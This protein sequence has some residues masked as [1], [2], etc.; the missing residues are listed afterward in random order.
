[1]SEIISTAIRSVLLAEPNIPT[2][3]TPLPAVRSPEIVSAADFRNLEP[4]RFVATQARVQDHQDNSLLAGESYVI[5]SPTSLDYYQKLQAGLD[6]YFP[7]GMTLQ[8][9]SNIQFRLASLTPDDI[10]A[11]L[12]KAEDN[13]YHYI[14]LSG[15][16]FESFSP[17]YSDNGGYLVIECNITV[18]T[19]GGQD[20]RG[21]QIQYHKATQRFAWANYL[22]NFNNN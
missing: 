10:S 5:G 19:E 20:E 22:D 13:V 15:V 2:S 17:R 9:L 7:E 16:S 21:L 12:D 14:P 11:I 3:I 8:D 4:Y 6:R 18:K 1:M